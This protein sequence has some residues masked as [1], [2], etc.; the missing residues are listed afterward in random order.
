MEPERAPPAGSFSRARVVIG[1]GEVRAHDDQEWVGALVL[2][3]C[4]ELELVTR[5]G[6]R[7]RFE[8]GAVL[9]LT[10]L[11]LRALRNPGP[12]PAELSVFRR[13]P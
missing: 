13:H 10:G 6:A 9:W 5:A 12:H 7:C 8:Q 2:L 1:P 4:G 3:R 11:S